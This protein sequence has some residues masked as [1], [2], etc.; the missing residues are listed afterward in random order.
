MPADFRLGSWLVQPSQNAISCNGHRSRLEPKVVDVLVC[1]AEH[2]GETVSKEQ[3]IRAVWGETFVSD[4]VLTRCVSELR[5]ALGDDPKAPRFI[6]TIPRKGY[7]LLEKVERSA[8]AIPVPAPK[9]RWQLGMAGLACVMIAFA[10]FVHSHRT[11][12]SQFGSIIPVDI[13]QTQ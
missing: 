13:R 7:R 8:P 3:L 12:A 11:R 2:S 9:R 5:K 4:D 1:L 6:E 10:G